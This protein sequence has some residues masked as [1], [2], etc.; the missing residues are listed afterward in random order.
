MG[1]SGLKSSLDTV[2]NKMLLN[3][4]VNLLLRNSP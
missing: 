3:K 1:L 2:F 4:L